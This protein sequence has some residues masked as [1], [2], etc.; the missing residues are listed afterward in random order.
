MIQMAKFTTKTVEVP[1]EAPAVDTALVVRTV[2]YL[3]AIANAIAAYF[4]FDLNIPAK[5]ESVYQ[6]VSVVFAVG[7]FAH[8][9]FKHNNV[10]KSA[11]IKAVVGNQVVQK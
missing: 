6:V 9:Y 5:D 11:R 8:A 1:V 2:V 4:G 10:T 3:I 7:S